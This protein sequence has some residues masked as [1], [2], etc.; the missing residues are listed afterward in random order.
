MV[1]SH[2]NEFLACPRCGYP[3]GST[4]DPDCPECGLADVAQRMIPGTLC[5]RS[6]LHRFAILVVLATFVLVITGGNVSSRDAGLSVPDGFTVYGYFLW[7]FP[8][9]QWI[10]GIFH[11]HIHRLKGSVVG[12]MCIA[13]AI[14][15]WRTQQQ[16]RWLR[17]FG[18]STLAMVIVQGVLGGLRVELANWMP[19]LA[20][21][22]AVLHGVMGQLFLCMT[23]LIAAATSKWWLAVAERQDHQ[24]VASDGSSPISG[25]A[26]IAVVRSLSIAFL[27]VLLV[28]LVIGAAMRH[29]A[30]GLAIPDFPSALGGIVP[31]LEPGAIEAAYDTLIG[32]EDL[33]LGGYPAPWQVAI[34]FA[35]RLWAIAVL[36]VGFWL[37]TRAAGQ[38][39][40]VRRPAMVIALLLV[41]QL[42]LGAAIVWTGRMSNVATAHQAMGAMTLATAALLT[43]RLYLLSHHVSGSPPAVGRN[44]P[45]A[46]GGGGA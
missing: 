42:A 20:T 4:R 44:Y 33:P 13:L 31:P 36:V 24:S 39:A 27:L 5:H 10:G 7:N 21:P 35:H 12:M 32:D 17:W 6:W 14:W 1:S 30:S 22:F 15:L 8:I 16:R 40:V 26:S 25:S 23:V 28:Q 11:E 34:H 37:V 19:A 45:M 9:D 2:N 29:T 41:V 46:L 18:V 43:M 3:A 38:I